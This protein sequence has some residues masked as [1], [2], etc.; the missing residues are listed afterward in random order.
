MATRKLL[1]DYLE[2]TWEYLETTRRLHGDYLKTT[3]RL[4]GDYL[5]TTRRLVENYNME[6]T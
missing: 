2:N 3:W 5:E 4:I 1:G 6:A